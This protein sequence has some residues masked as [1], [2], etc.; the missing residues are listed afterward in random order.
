[1]A[2]PR[3]PHTHGTAHDCCNR[4]SS[5]FKWSCQADTPWLS[6]ISAVQRARR[7]SNKEGCSATPLL[8]RIH[9]IG[10]LTL[11]HEAALSRKEHY[12]LLLLHRGARPEARDA[13][14]RNVLHLALQLRLFAC[15]P[16]IL[17]YCPKVGRPALTRGMLHLLCSSD[18][19]GD[20][21]EEILALQLIASE[22]AELL[23]R[24]SWGRTCLHQAAKCGNIVM[25]RQLV[26]C[27]SGPE[28]VAAQDDDGLTPAG[29]AE[30]RGH[31][32]IAVML[33]E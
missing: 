31:R 9:G 21:G 13:R 27:R 24:D 22:G 26:A 14:G 28:L 4:G 2:C 10:K 6:R 5:R 11:L 17:A 29:L 3:F 7:R 12:V 33:R 25:A 23:E 30:A 20:G 19:Q 15:V 8:T 32:A 16:A 18:V 1:M